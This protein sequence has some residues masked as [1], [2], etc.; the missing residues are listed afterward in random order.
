MLTIVLCKFYN[1]PRQSV[2]AIVFTKVIYKA[3][4]STLSASGEHKRVDKGSSEFDISFKI[5]TAHDLNNALLL[6]PGKN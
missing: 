1:D 4:F 2:N 6:D 5:S 3:V